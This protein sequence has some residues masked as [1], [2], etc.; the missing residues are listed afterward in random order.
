MSYVKIEEVLPKELIETIQQYVDGKYIYIPRKEEKRKAWGESTNIKNEIKS[1]NKEIFN[2][3]KNG[4]TVEA[5]IIEF[6]LSKKSIQ[7]IIYQ[8]KK[9][10][11]MGK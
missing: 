3:Y 11:E 1:R 6:Y 10:A 5:L 2:K 7:R 4:T 8:E 9:K